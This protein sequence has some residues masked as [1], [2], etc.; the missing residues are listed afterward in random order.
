ML[1]VLSDSGNSTV[2]DCEIAYQA[3]WGL[4]ASTSSSST[5]TRNTI[6]SADGGGIDVEGGFSTTVSHNKISNVGMRPGYGFSGVNGA[7]GMQS[8][9]STTHITFAENEVWQV[10]YIGLRF[11]GVGNLIEKNI[12]HD[13]MLTLDDGGCM[14]TW[15]KDASTGHVLRNN[16]V[17]NSISNV[18]S[19]I[20]GTWTFSVGYYFDYGVTDVLLE[21]NTVYN[22]PNGVFV[23]YACDNITI[24]D[25]VI[26]N[27][28]QGVL[29]AQ[30]FEEDYVTNIK[31]EGNTIAGISASQTALN[32]GTHTEKGSFTTANNVYCFTLN[33]EPF[34]L[35]DHHSFTWWQSNREPSATA[36]PSTLDSEYSVDKILSENLIQNGDFTNGTSG[37]VGWPS[38]NSLLSWQSACTGMNGGCLK[39][40]VDDTTNALIYANRFATTANGGFQLEA[41]ASA[42]QDVAITT[43]FVRHHDSFDSLGWSWTFTAT[44]EP[45]HFTHVLVTPKGDNLTRLDFSKNTASSTTVLLDNVVLYSVSTKA[46]IPGQE[47]VLLVNPTDEAVKQDLPYGYDAYQTIAGQTTCSVELSPFSSVV[48]IN[49]STGDCDVGSQTTVVLPLI[50]AMLCASVLLLL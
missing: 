39:W 25:N 11:D 30:N 26:Y 27:T 46:R 35:T 10:G 8:T 41:T 33:T 2:A 13:V 14:Y 44:A 47:I 28:S 49:P 6:T 45:T 4:Y 21:G 19:A 36:C 7:I 20:P 40:T 38:T 16:V 22:C 9:L 5:F 17:Y 31:I 12:I 43:N 32:L 29:F 48:L 18:S 23:Q 1:N 3:K 50:A 34:Y 42:P 24:K 15:G 37:W